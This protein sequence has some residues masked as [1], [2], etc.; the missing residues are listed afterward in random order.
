M[1]KNIKIY[2]KTN[3]DELDFPLS[4]DGIYAKKYLTPYIKNR[5]SFYIDNVET[6]LKILSI[7][8]L[9]LPITINDKEYNNSYVVSPYTHYVTYSKEELKE[10]KNPLL[11][12]ILKETVL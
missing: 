9:V 7:D 12:I 10:L 5:T 2:D 3:I 11:E 4:E 1:E 8:N 6:D